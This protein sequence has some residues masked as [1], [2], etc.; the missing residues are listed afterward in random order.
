MTLFFTRV[1]Y[2]IFRTVSPKI[3]IRQQRYAYV[4]DL[5]YLLTNLIPITAAVNQNL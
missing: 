2:H 4:I 1:T 5:L 3:V